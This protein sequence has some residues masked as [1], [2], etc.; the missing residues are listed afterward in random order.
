M[1]S[2]SMRR[3]VATMRSQNRVAST[4][5]IPACL[6]LCAVHTSAQTLRIPRAGTEE[7]L[8]AEA[9]AE[10]AA[11]T[12]TSKTDTTAAVPRV[13]VDAIDMG[14]AHS[15]EFTIGGN[16]SG[17]SAMRAGRPGKVWWAPLHHARNMP[18]LVVRG[19]SL[20]TGSDTVRFTSAKVAWPVV[21]PG[22][23]VP[24]TER[25]YFFPSGITIPNPG[26]WLLIAT[27]GANWGCFIL[28][29]RS[30]AH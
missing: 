23:P 10:G 1:H 17:M 18:A 24:E 2:L 13:C 9:A 19:R 11:F 21:V 3:N 27:S 6:L 25:K 14:P 7:Q 26:R 15:G 20:T 30:S 8:R 16:L 29:V 12:R 4:L 28:T 22:V 5:L